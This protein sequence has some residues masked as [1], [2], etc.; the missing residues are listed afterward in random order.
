MRRHAGAGWVRGWIRRSRR[1][2]REASEE[3]S[4]FLLPIACGGCGRQDARLCDDCAGSLVADAPSVRRVEGVPVFSA[5][6]YT[7]RVKRIVLAF[8]RDGRTDLRGP[9]ADAL[10]RSLSASRAV[11]TGTGLEVVPAPASAEGR[12]R[13]G[14]A[15]VLLLVRSTGLRPSPVLRRRRRTADQIGLGVAERGVNMTGSLEARRALAGRR[16]VVVDDVVTSG[17][18]LSECVRALREAGGEVVACAT[19]A[20]TPKR[21]ATPR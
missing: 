1:M 14:Y 13:R 10:G 21:A 5:A 11:A 2:L 18:T 4:A 9:L 16:F 20:A 8:K 12:R 7:G 15:P 17:A 6:S 3:A 19:L